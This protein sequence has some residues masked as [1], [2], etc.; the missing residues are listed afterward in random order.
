MVMA[1]PTKEEIDFFASMGEA[2]PTMVT[3]VYKV[4]SGAWTQVRI[5]STVD[6]GNLRK[7]DL[8]ITNSPTRHHD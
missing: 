8:Y 5:W 3:D 6:L 1:R 7:V 4:R 2:T